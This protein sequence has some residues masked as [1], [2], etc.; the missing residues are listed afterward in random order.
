[1]WLVKEVNVQHLIFL[2][3]NTKRTISLL[4][5]KPI[6]EDIEQFLILAVDRLHNGVCALRPLYKK[7]KTNQNIEFSIGLILRAIISDYMIALELHVETGNV[8]KENSKN[9]ISELELNITIKNEL[10]VLCNRYNRD[11]VNKEK[12]NITNRLNSQEIDV[13]TANKEYSELVN[14]FPECFEE[15]NNDGSIPKIK[16]TY[17]KPLLTK[18]FIDLLEIR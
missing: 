17:K 14:R 2:F 16:D 4:K 18:D 10:N 15:Y 1:M 3:G 7:F 11:G 9:N 6:Y 8:I 12:N 13:A 5:D